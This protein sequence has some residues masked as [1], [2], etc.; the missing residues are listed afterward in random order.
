MLTT[1]AAD[2]TNVRAFS[3]G[4]G[5]AILVLHP[6]CGRRDVVEEGGGPALEAHSGRA[7]GTAISTDWT[8]PPTLHAPSPKWSMT[9]A[10][11]R[12]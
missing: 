7:P 2:G 9:A 12:G 8:S 5:R 4:Q 6:G 3:E 1:T 11:S 10:R